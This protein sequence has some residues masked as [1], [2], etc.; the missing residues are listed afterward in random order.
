MRHIVAGI[1]G[2]CLLG[3]GLLTFIS[4]QL[5]GAGAQAMSAE[6]ASV[7]WGIVVTDSTGRT[8]PN[9]LVVLFVDGQETGRTDSAG[10][11][12]GQVPRGFARAGQSLAMREGSV[13]VLAIPP[14]PRVLLYAFAGDTAGLPFDVVTCRLTVSRDGKVRCPETS[15][16][17]P[18][19]GT[20]LMA[21]LLGL[22]LFPLAAI[23]AREV[24]L[25]PKEWPAAARSIAVLAMAAALSTLVVL[26]FVVTGV[27][28]R[29]IYQLSD[30]FAGAVDG[31]LAALTI[32]VGAYVFWTQVRARFVVPR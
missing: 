10:H 20:W 5:A 9:R 2:I 16:A 14:G 23:S 25:W 19:L 22:M 4:Q 24:A 26:M 27:I 13:H 1:I 32:V 15:P 28:D 3:A 30:V 6:R 21:G 8:L 29:W 7:D 18:E 31:L 12:R 17:V 11:M